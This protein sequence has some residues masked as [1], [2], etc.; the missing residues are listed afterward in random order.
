MREASQEPAEQGDLGVKPAATEPD[1]VQK[2]D[3]VANESAAPPISLPQ[4]APEGPSETANPA[5]S[6]PKEEEVPANAADL[7]EVRP[8]HASVQETP[9]PT[10]TAEHTQSEAA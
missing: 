10:D 4:Q 1:A 8:E 2:D 6:S 3:K 9:K 7:Q 5:S